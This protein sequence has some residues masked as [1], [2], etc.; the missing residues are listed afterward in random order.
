VPN[1]VRVESRYRAST[2]ISCDSQQG[3][4]RIER[5]HK[6]LDG[7]CRVTTLVLVYRSSVVENATI[8]QR[9][10]GVGPN[11]DKPLE[12]DSLDRYRRSQRGLYLGAVRLLR[13]ISHRES[14]YGLTVS[15]PPAGR[16]GSLTI[17]WR[18]GILNHP[19][20]TRT[21]VEY[22]QFDLRS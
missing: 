7:R 15:V 12:V 14:M 1:T 17:V 20:Q 21:K 2:A 10:S 5:S 16:I 11:A 8:G 22:R 18:L 19:R 13:G 4:P 3:N 9:H 6:L